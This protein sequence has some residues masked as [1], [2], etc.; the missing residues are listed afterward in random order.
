MST[1]TDCLFGPFTEDML[2]DPSQ[3]L[4]GDAAPGPLGFVLAAHGVYV[5]V[6]G[7]VKKQRSFQY[8]G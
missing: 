8:N 7:L 4:C 6:R 2:C 3:H 1:E 5:C